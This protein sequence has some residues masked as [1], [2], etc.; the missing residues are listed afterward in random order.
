[1]KYQGLSEKRPSPE[2]YVPLDQSPWPGAALILRTQGNPLSAAQSARE[3]MAKVDPEVAITAV[4]SMD[5]VADDSLSAARL[6]TWLIGSFAVV[7]LI[8]AA[9]GIYALISFSVTQS[10][11]GL[12]V[13]MAL[14]ADR[15]NI[16]RLVLSQAMILTAGGLVLGLGGA[17]VLTRLLSSLL[18]QVAPDDPLTLAAVCVLLALVA[19]LAGLIPAVR[20][21][22]LDPMAALRVE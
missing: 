13:R 10:T 17:F 11:H 3:A 1:V 16:L 8:M 20:A 4:K 7:A 21:S 18:F 6:R 5:Q 12:G 22:R 19:L 2:I 15:G 14:G 9:L